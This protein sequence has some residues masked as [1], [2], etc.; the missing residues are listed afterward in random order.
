MCAQMSWSSSRQDHGRHNGTHVVVD[1]VVVVVVVDVDGLGVVVGPAVVDDVDVD[2]VDG[3]AVDV[4]GFEQSGNGFGAAVVGAAVVTGQPVVARQGL[5]VDDEVELVE[6]EDVDD[7]EVVDVDVVVV[8][9]VVVV[10]SRLSVEVQYSG[11]S[12][13]DKHRILYCW[14]MN[15]FRIQ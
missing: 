2:V 12:D 11:L 7:V 10:G 14:S 6:V 15:V 9:E 5:G 4:A 13:S 1:D 8:V 3:P